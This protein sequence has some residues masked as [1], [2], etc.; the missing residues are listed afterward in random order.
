MNF[1]AVFLLHK[2]KGECQG[3]SVLDYNVEIISYLERGPIY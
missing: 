1:T 2:L 3:I